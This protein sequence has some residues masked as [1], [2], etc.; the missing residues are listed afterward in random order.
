MTIG[1]MLWGI[2]DEVTGTPPSAQTTAIYTATPTSFGLLSAWF[3]GP[4]DMGFF[5]GVSRS[6]IDAIY[7]SGR[8]IEVIIWL[9][10]SQTTLDYAVSSTFLDT[11]LPAIVNA[12]KGAGTTY[13]CLFTELET[14]YDKS[15][16]AGRQYRDALKTQYIK[17][18]QSIHAL[19]PRAKVGIGFTGQF[20]SGSVGTTRNL[21]YWQD[22]QGSTVS[23]STNDNAVTLDAYT[24][25]DALGTYS[26]IL[27]SQQMQGAVTYET[28]TTQSLLVNQIIN[29]VNQ[30]N[31]MYP[32]KPIGISHFK[33]WDDPKSGGVPVAGADV[34]AQN[35]WGSIMSSLF[36]T[37][38]FND[39]TSKN[40][41]VWNFM[42]DHYINL[43]GAVQGTT[44]AWLSSHYQFEGTT[45]VLLDYP[46]FPGADTTPW[47]SEFTPTVTTTGVA[48]MLAGGLRAST[49]NAG[50]Q[51][52]TVRGILN[53]AAVNDQ[54]DLG[55]KGQFDFSSAS[56]QPDCSW[57]F[58][59][60]A[61]GNWSS[62]SGIRPTTS[63]RLN[64]HTSGDLRL[65]HTLNGGSLRTDATTTVPMTIGHSK[66]FKFEVE[67][68][69]L[70][71]K[72]WDSF[73]SEPLTGGPDNDGFILKATMTVDIVTTGGR[74]QLILVGPQTASALNG[75][76]R[77]RNLQFY[78][79]ASAPADTPVTSI[80]KAK[81]RHARGRRR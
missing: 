43:S 72:A 16:L 56:P 6:S 61:A 5:T 51:T 9:A 18:Y 69:E 32:T 57:R 77:V 46:T 44:V 70:R 30:L 24:G 66:L 76:G 68:N 79:F 65:E 49:G 20:W 78:N 22:G 52:D 13:F 7:A 71:A 19:A 33:V 50:G 11:D 73:E 2:G 14:Y 63:V 55:V 15:T 67:G 27:W 29:Q 28:G 36:T 64:W 47:P 39:L 53:N 10:A 37:A 38:E 21:K 1:K 3:N 8:A 12:Y 31:S 48:D 80:F 62:S 40:L 58:H 59:L 60:R 4:S 35:T 23:G 42:T 81:P 45:G 17:A 74:F 54:V 26:D 34:N 25:A 41:S 75:Y